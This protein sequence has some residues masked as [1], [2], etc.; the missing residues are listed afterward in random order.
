MLRTPVENPSIPAD[1]S[2]GATALFPEGN[3]LRRLRDALGARFQT[4]AFAHL[5]P[6]LGPP[7]RDPARLARVPVLPCL[8]GLSERQAAEHVRRGMD[9]QEAWALPLAAPGFDAS[10][11][12]ECRP[13]LI[14]GHAEPVRFETFLTRVQEQ[15]WLKARGRQRTDSPPVLAAIRTLHRVTWVGETV[16]H[17]RPALA[18]VAPDGLQ[19]QS[20]PDGFDRSRHRLADSRLPSTPEERQPLAVTMGRDGFPLRTAVRAPTAPL[21]LRER[22]A[23]EGWR[24]VGRQPYDAYAPASAGRW[25]PTA[26]VPPH[27]LLLCSPYDGDAR[28][29]TKRETHWTGEKVHRTE[30]GDAESPPRL[31]HVA[32]TPATTTDGEV[33]PVMPPHRAA[34]GLLPRAPLLDTGASAADHLVTSRLTPTVELVGPVLPDT[35]WQARSPAGCAMACLAMEWG[36][37]TVTCPQGH[38]RRRWTPPPDSPHGGQELIAR[39]C[40]PAPCAVCPVRARC[41]Q[42][43][44]GPRTMTLR[45]Q[46]HHEALQAARQC[47]TTAAFQAA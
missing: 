19:R 21:G 1:T 47:Q 37:Q 10:V 8:A 40:D 29:A 23:V 33:T 35:R 13:R 41:P 3:R 2:R 44:T 6:A 42:A 26:D 24:R 14:T 5:L 45:P 17:A 27:A 7:A 12:S 4:A 46:Q 16:R 32:T 15:G 20:T 38:R 28:D 30:T 36:A 34:Q 9:G 25:R 11:L 22:P 39:Q 31:T 18:T 43:K